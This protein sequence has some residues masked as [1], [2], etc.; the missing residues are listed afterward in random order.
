MFFRATD[1]C[2][3]YCYNVLDKEREVWYNE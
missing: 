1:K 3:E 2:L